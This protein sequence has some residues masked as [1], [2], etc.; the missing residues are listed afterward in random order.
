[1]AQAQARHLFAVERITSPFGV[2]RVPREPLPQGGG[3]PE[4]DVVVRLPFV[5]DEGCS[6]PCP[7]KIAHGVEFRSRIGSARETSA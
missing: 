4:I 5:I 6:H 2:F 1:M 7:P 3:E